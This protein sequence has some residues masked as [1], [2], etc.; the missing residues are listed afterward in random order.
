MFVDVIELNYRGGRIPKHER[1]G[2][3]V[4]RGTI[5]IDKLWT[6][7]RLE[8]APVHAYL[9]PPSLEPLY[10]AKVRYWR[11]RTVVL[12]GQQRLGNAKRKSETS[13]EQV[14]LCRILT[15]AQVAEE[16]RASRPGQPEPMRW[17]ALDQS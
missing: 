1:G 14:W 7:D 12:V 16:A 9:T 15:E 6:H 5:H 2:L 4:T 13:Y 3:P 10:G 8:K 17:P 11:G